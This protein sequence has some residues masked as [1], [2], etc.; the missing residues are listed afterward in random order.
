MVLLVAMTPRAIGES[1]ALRVK[2]R[3]RGRSAE[4]RLLG[5]RM[6]D[7]RDEAKTTGLRLGDL[8]QG[9]EGEPIDQ[10]QAS[11]GESGEALARRRQIRRI[12]KGKARP[13]REML[14]LPARAAKL[15]DQPA[16]IAIAA[17]QRREIAGNDE[18]EI[19]GQSPPRTSP[20]PHGTR[21]A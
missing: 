5:Q 4:A 12:G 1:A 2:E 8:R 6:M 21:S 14:D 17:G 20:A 10:D 11:L 7:E 9:A 15:G 16:V 3:I 19:S 18:A 13:Q